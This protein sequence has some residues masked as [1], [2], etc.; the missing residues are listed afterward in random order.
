MRRASAKLQQLLDL[1]RN[2]EEP[3]GGVLKRADKG[4][5]MRSYRKLPGTA[6]AGG[7]PPGIVHA[8]PKNYPLARRG[9]EGGPLA[10]RERRGVRVGEG[11]AGA[12][13]DRIRALL[14]RLTGKQKSLPGEVSHPLLAD[15][16]SDFKE[17]HPG[18]IA[19]RGGW[20]GKTLK[21]GGAA[22]TPLILGNALRESI[23]GNRVA[24]MIEG[25][26]PGDP[27]MMLEGLRREELLRARQ[28]RLMQND[29]VAMMMLKRLM[30]GKQMPPKLAAGEY[31]V[32]MG[33]EPPDAPDEDVQA[34]LASLG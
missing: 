11:V 31:M 12:G 34:L 7:E 21:I 33:M 23:K 22:I 2:R 9:V 19:S 3:V 29:P 8:E 27:R 28:S 6:A 26:T 13:E 30:A 20:L 1:V 24:T 15:L 25:M 14:R 16:A 32:G 4:G 17:S 5:K 10:V 18:K